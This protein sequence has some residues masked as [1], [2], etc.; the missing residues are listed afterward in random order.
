MT[1]WKITYERARQHDRGWV[2]PHERTRFVVE[3]DLPMGVTDSRSASAYLY[4]QGRIPK[5]HRLLN[6]HPW[7][8]AA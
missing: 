5:G 6:A 8:E 7:K 3:V 1:I 2:Q 4:G